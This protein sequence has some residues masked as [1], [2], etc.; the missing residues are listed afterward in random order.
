MGILGTTTVVTS[1]DRTSKPKLIQPSNREWVIVIQSINS[2]SWAVPPFLVFKGKWHLASWYE[3]E[4]FPDGQRAAVSENGW[5]TNEVTLEQ[6]KHFE[7]FTRTKTAG[8]Y[9]LL[10]L[11]GH[12]SHYSVEFEE[13]YRINDILTLCMPTH[14]S[15]LL[16]PLDIECFAPLKKAYSRQIENLVRSRITHISKEAFIP[17]FVEAFKATMTKANI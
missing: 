10:V 9:R 17:V 12:E 6:L 13:Y 15:H 11:D 3:K 1:S 14:L 4:Q 16:Q 8:K 2:S 5:T 7:K